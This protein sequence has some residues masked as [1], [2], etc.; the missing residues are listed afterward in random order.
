MMEQDILTILQHKR[1]YEAQVAIMRDCSDELYDVDQS[2]HANDY[3]LLKRR[4]ALIDHWLDYLSPSERYVVDMRLFQNIAWPNIADQI[5]ENSKGRLPCD[6]R[7]VQR[8][9]ERALAR[10]NKL[11]NVRFGDSMD[12]LIDR[13]Q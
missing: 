9:L 4:L 10:L 11:M 5:Q 8:Q 13:M 1:Q 12:F 6:E 2:Q 7:T 3:A